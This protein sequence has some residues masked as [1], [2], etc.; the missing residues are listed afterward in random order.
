MCVPHRDISTI[1]ECEGFFA[2]DI[3]RGICTSVVLPLSFDN[4]SVTNK[5][6]AVG[7]E[8]SKKSYN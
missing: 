5:T 7:C 2:I 3:R 1:R 4:L 6:I 8:N